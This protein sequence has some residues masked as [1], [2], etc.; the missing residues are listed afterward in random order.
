MSACIRKL[1]DELSSLPIKQLK[2][3]YDNCE[4]ELNKM[5][6]KRMILLRYTIKTRKKLIEKKKNE[7]TADDI[8]S[9]AQESTTKINKSQ[10]FGVDDIDSESE[11]NK[12]FEIKSSET[13]LF[14]RMMCESDIAIKKDKNIK[15]EFVPPYEDL[16]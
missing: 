8:E 2:K 6:L 15:T 11:S 9:D 12:K 7:F 4:D 16:Q 13:L 14:D 1:A 3:L 10:T 5:I